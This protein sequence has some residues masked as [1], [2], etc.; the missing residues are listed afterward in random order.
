MQLFFSYAFRPFFLL[1]P[2]YALI[3]VAYWS[4]AFLG[5]WQT[6]T[7]ALSPSLWHA[8]ELLYG[9]AGAGIA[10]FLFTAI[11]NWTGRPPLAGAQLAT[12]FGLWLCARLGYLFS[13]VVPMSFIILAD[14]GFF[15]LLTAFAAREVAS[16]SNKR[17]YVVIGLLGALTISNVAFYGDTDPSSAL[18]R[19]ALHAGLWTVLILINLIGGRIIPAFS[20]NWLNLQAQKRGE[21]PASLPIAFNR[22]DQLVIAITLVYGVLFVVSAP[23][24]VLIAA[25]L[26]ACVGQFVR[27][28]RWK[29]WLVASEPLLWILHLAYLW[30]P[31]GFGLL[32]LSHL[33]LVPQS[34]GLH[35]LGS[36]AV[37]MMILAVASR[38]AL[39]HTGRPLESSPTLTA[40]YL[41]LTLA[42]LLRVLAAV[43]L[44]TGTFLLAA[45]LC[46]TL[47]LLL[48]LYLYLPILTQPPANS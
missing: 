37:T 19:A 22:T 41:L 47:G 42:A 9:F 33:E 36:G 43:G 20:R 32:A 8:H 45:S 27:L 25:S 35:A 14:T 16:A 46:W 5:Y 10:G 28:V 17:N 29:S 48:F 1:A 31:V 21:T 13:D 12:L 18:P 40:S 30:L 26:I 3:S 2:L 4:G 6:P 44:E 24:R 34:A 23:A 38:A 39:G 7:F 11:P 15:F